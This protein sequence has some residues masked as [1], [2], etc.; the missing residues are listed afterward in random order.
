M[1]FVIF[2][3]I[4]NVAFGQD[5]IYGDEIKYGDVARHNARSQY[6]YVWNNLDRYIG[7]G[8]DNPA[9]LSLDEYKV[10]M[11]ISVL[12][13]KEKNTTKIIYVSGIKH[14]KI[15]NITNGV[16]RIAATDNKPNA[17][18]YINTEMM[19]NVNAE[20]IAAI[21]TH[22][23][24]HH[25]GYQDDQ[26][27]V[28]DK[29]GTVVARAF[30]NETSTLDLSAI[31]IPNVSFMIQNMI[32]PQ[33]PMISTPAHRM[34]SIYLGFGAGGF[35]LDQDYIYSVIKAGYFKNDCP[36]P[37]SITFTYAAPFRWKSVPPSNQNP[38][39]KTVE[40]LS[41]FVIGCTDNGQT[42]IIKT[43][44]FVF[45]PI[46]K[47]NGYYILDYNKF[48]VQFV[49]P[50]G[51]NLGVIDSI[52][53]NKKIITKKD[54]WEGEARITMDD[55]NNFDSCMA[56]L[57]N[58]NFPTTRDGELL[59]ISF[60]SCQIK[61]VGNNQYQ[62]RFSI[63][64]D[65]G[66]IGGQYFL[67][68]IFLINSKDNTQ[69]ILKPTFRQFLEVK[70]QAQNPLAITRFKLID[71]RGND[72]TETGFRKFKKGDIA[73]LSLTMNKKFDGFVFLEFDAVMIS[74]SM[75]AQTGFFT[76]IDNQSGQLFG[77]ELRATD[78]NDETEIIIKFDPYEN[79][80][81]ILKGIQFKNFKFLSNEFESIIVKFPD[82]FGII[83]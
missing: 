8:I 38:E 3:L 47:T 7:K 25:L 43:S 22:E 80:S 66:I 52:V 28:L 70:K 4:A 30:R 83:M 42:K 41:D 1:F 54:V 51:Q 9:G 53:F 10:L 26:D 74:P 78:S 46:I 48:T 62:V 73:T 40:A 79:N 6:E 37:E 32:T 2:F 5:F 50:Q 63:E 24:G 15:F 67:K 61:P 60:T 77:L 19:A 82:S 39:G 57:S 14:P 49:N 13:E 76:Y 23:L 12:F 27:R 33:D 34:A 17:T 81:Y 75:N 58:Q 65:I 64:L 44:L 16:H 68:E 35:N 56:S 55:S 21:F 18:I 11:H 29:I 45:S 36:K 72:V 59:A 31:K 69:N 20:G 71:S